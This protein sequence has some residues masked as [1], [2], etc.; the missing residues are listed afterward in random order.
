MIATNSVSAM[1]D[2]GKIPRGIYKTDSYINMIPMG[3]KT[4]TGKARKFIRNRSKKGQAMIV[5]KVKEQI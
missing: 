2:M 4:A 3:K 5:K 1:E